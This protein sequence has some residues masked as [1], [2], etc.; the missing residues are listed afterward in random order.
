MYEMWVQLC[1][2][3]MWVNSVD[4]LKQ[5][6]VEVWHCLH[7]CTVICT[8]IRAVVRDDCWFRFR[9]NFCTFCIFH[10]RF[11]CI[12]V[13]FFMFFMYFMFLNIFRLSLVVLISAGDWLERLVSEITHYV[14]YHVSPFPHS[15]SVVQ[16][17]GWWSDSQQTLE[18]RSV[19]HSSLT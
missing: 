13:S 17:I 18:S 8:H 7:L 6:V 12:R 3:E 4:E 9:F 15:F 16:W 19:T 1:V 10:N 2:Y 5:K 14:L 11:V